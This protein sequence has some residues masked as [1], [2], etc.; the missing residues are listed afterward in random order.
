MGRVEDAVPR[1][2]NPSSEV[3]EKL[4]GDGILGTS[5]G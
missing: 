4:P 2:A 1:G 3:S 5:R